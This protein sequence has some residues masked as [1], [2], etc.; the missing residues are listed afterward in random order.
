MAVVMGVFVLSFAFFFFLFHDQGQ[1]LT[2]RN[3]VRISDSLVI[4]NQAP[5]N[6]YDHRPHPVLP[7]RK[8]SLSAG[9][10]KKPQMT[11]RSA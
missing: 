4:M 6:P 7:S 1:L 11:N 8:I 2:S 10:L 3:D 5:K 9:E